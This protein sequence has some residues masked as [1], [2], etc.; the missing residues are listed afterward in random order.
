ML[1]KN[2][3]YYLV[4]PSQSFVLSEK[5]LMKISAFLQGI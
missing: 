1:E 5:Y 4:S 3:K 2:P